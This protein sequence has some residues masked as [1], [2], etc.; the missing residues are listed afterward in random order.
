MKKA[1]VILFATAALLAIGGCSTTQPVASEEV[2]ASVE[3]SADATTEAT[4]EAATE[5]PTETT[6]EAASEETSASAEDVSASPAAEATGAT[7]T[8]T[9]T[10][11]SGELDL[12]NLPVTLEDAHAKFV[13]LVPEGVVSSIETDTSFGETY[14]DVEGFNAATEYKVRI[15]P[16]TGEAKIKNQEALDKEESTEIYKNNHTLDITKILSL[17]DAGAKA[18]AEVDGTVTEWSLDME[19]GSPIYEIKVLDSATNRHKEV[20]V[21]A[22]TGIVVKV[23]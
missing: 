6:T 20:K 10:T 13:E 19:N 21:N 12:L 1:Y 22:A 15:N 3:A 16:T 5:A 18:V 8:A 7:S 2:S 4:T 9:S 11:T 17:P 23:G 14:I